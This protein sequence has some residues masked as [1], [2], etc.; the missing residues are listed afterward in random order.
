MADLN[1]NTSID[2]RLDQLAATANTEQLATFIAKVAP[3]CVQSARFPDYFR[4]WEESGIHVTPVHF[5]QP[6]PD[7]RTLP[8]ALWQHASELPVLEMN[9]AVQLDLLDNCFPRFRDEYSKFPS[10]PNNR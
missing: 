7:T 8:A 6:I 5:Y 3:R 2:C 1:L 4:L 10:K 9:D